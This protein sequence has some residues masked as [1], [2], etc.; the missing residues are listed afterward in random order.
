MS[1]RDNRRS[2]SSFAKMSLMYRVTLVVEY[3]GWVQGPTISQNNRRL[4]LFVG[5]DGLVL[6]NHV[7]HARCK[8]N[9]RRQLPLAAAS[10]LK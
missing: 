9:P 10:G 7:Q 6:Q 1:L 5:P 4:L 2:W 8:R 3:L